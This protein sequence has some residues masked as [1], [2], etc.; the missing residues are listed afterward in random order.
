MD[1][2]NIVLRQTA[3]VAVGQI[4]C[5]AIM[6]AVF[7]ALGYWDNSVLIGG[8]VGTLIAVG[9][10]LL[11]GIGSGIAA[12]KAQNQDVK[13]AQAVMSLSMLLRYGLMFVFLIAGYKSG[14]CNIFALV[15]PMIFTQPIM[16]VGAYFTKDR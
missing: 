11:M 15:L 8:I 13:G 2:R 3:L 4:I 16:M 9:N 1:S 7:A 6:Y 14:L 12:D 5:C 10:F